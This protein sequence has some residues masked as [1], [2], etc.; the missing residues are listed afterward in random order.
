MKDAVT[1]IVGAGAVLDFDHK[2][3]VPLVKNIT[4]EVLDLKIQN[5]YGEDTLLIRYVH[6]NI[7]ARL[8]EVGNPE[9]RRFQQ[10]YLNFEEL[11]HVLEMC[12]TYSSC[13]CDE[14]YHWKAVP[15]FGTLV[16]PSTSLSDITTMDYLRAAIALE[17]RVMEIVNQYV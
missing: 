4:D 2:G 6:D 7:V 3:V 14:Y 17:N 12:Y 16:N 1:I 15:L 13:W 11:L 8:K 10:P 5:Y 9:V